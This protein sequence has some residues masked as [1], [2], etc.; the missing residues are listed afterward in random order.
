MINHIQFQAMSDV[1]TGANTFTV[2]EPLL[3][4]DLSYARLYASA[5]CINGVCALNLLTFSDN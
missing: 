3:F 4:A 1:K 2:R 5:C